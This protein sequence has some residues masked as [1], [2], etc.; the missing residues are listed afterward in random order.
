MHGIPGTFIAENQIESEPRRAMV[1]SRFRSEVGALYMRS[2]CEYLVRMSSMIQI[3]NVPD[4]LHRKMKARAALEGKSLSE[5]LLAELRRIAELPTP[6]EWRARLAT[7][8]PVS[9]T[10]DAAGAVRAERDSR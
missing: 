3:R 6:E 10:V 9:S 2:A 7:R 5:Y 4:D 1:L 8:E